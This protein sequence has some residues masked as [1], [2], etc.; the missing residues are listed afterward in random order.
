[1]EGYVQFSASELK[2][3]PASSFFGSEVVGVGG[4]NIVDAVNDRE[5]MGPAGCPITLTG[6]G[7]TYS[8]CNSVMQ[9]FTKTDAAIEAHDITASVNTA[10][11]S[12][13]STSDG[14]DL[15][16]AAS[17]DSLNTTQWGASATGLLN[18]TLN[19]ASLWSDILTEAAHGA[20]LAAGSPT[21]GALAG[22]TVDSVTC[23]TGTTSGV[24]IDGF[25]G[26]DSNVNPNY[27]LGTTPTNTSVTTMGIAGMSADAGMTQLKKTYSNLAD[28]LNTDQRKNFASVT[29]LKDADF[30]IKA[31]DSG[32]FGLA[33]RGYADDVMGGVDWSIHGN[34][35]HSKIPYARFKGKGGLYA[36]DV[37]GIFNTI[38]ALDTDFDGTLD[39]NFSATTAAAEQSM[40][41]GL[42]NSYYSGGVCN[43]ALGSILT[44]GYMNTIDADGSQMDA[45]TAAAAAHIAD[46]DKYNV[47]NI[48]TEQKKVARQALWEENIG[49]N[50][51]HNSAKCWQSAQDTTA[52]VATLAALGLT[53]NAT[54]YH[55]SL[56]NTGNILIAA[57]SPLNATTYQLI[58]PEDLTS[59][60][61]SGSTTINGTAVQLE[62][63]Y[64]PDFPL[65][66]NQGDQIGQLA[67]VNGAY[68]MLD[69]LAYNTYA[70]LGAS[71]TDNWGTQCIDSNATP[72][73]LL[74]NEAGDEITPAQIGVLTTADD[75]AGN[76]IASVIAANEGLSAAQ[77]LTALGTAAAT[78]ANY[79]FAE[80]N[81]A[82]A[83]QRW[84]ASTNSGNGLAHAAAAFHKAIRDGAYTIGLVAAEAGTAE[85][86]AAD[87]LLDG[88]GYVGLV[89]NSAAVAG[90][91]WGA[92]KAFNRSSLTPIAI[93]D[94]LNDYYSTPYIEYDVWTYDIG[95]TTSFNASHP[96]TQMLQADG[97]A[98][99]TEV[100]MVNISNMNDAANGF[101][102]RNGFQAGVGGEKCLGGL[103]GTLAAAAP[104]SFGAATGLT[105]LG[106]GM[107]DGLFGNGKYC[108]AQNGA[109][110]FSMTYRVIGSATY[111][112]ISNTAWSMNPSFVWS[113][114]PM[115]YGPS[116]VGG[117]VEGRSSLSL[118]LGFN[119]GTGIG[120]SLNY[121]NQLGD[122]FSNLSNDKDYISAS[123]SYAF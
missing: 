76:L 71:N 17:L 3:D 60:G 10:I 85:D 8:S 18:S 83:Y 45:V 117:F 109:D 48:L 101:V 80:D 20:F 72:T 7:S 4:K 54:N 69:L 28:V 36:G 114:D 122:E 88:A 119:K 39:S 86:A 105:H 32:Q 23:A 67:D 110:S 40:Y 56:R 75:A 118:G 73:D 87:T 1:M 82:I 33:L 49:G 51:T 100:G 113:H 9:N 96:V 104:Y 46:G 37:L 47:Y 81:G 63:N 59:L 120:V 95:T 112:N 31:A 22:F 77:F 26:C 2:L 12:F 16:M 61:F 91:Y 107:A 14:G 74:C 84:L 52:G 121:V 57:L 93:A 34:K 11:K 27:V 97:S 55:E 92:L 78:D 89:N 108:E 123:V 5:A 43:A 99:L 115:G 102:A 58:Y 38:S 90:A 44:A 24:G 19:G 111:N 64:R 29:F 13:G 6:W 70:G 98:I 25:S 35:Y 15:L 79:A 53:D 106:A 62:V 65:A 50:F 116:S 68:D 42:F 94:T 103:G 21:T 41:N 66:T 30:E